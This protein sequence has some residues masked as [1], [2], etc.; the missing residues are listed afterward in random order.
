MRAVGAGR[1]IDHAPIDAA[2]TDDTT[3]PD[4]TPDFGQMIQPIKLNNYPE[5]VQ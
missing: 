5:I 1:R 4:S 3:Y 2:E